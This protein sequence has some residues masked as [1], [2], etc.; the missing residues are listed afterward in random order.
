M[1]D[2]SC[3]CNTHSCALLTS[4]YLIILFLI[5]KCI[6]ICIRNNKTNNK[7]ESNQPKQPSIPIPTPN[8]NNTS[9]IPILPTNS[10]STAT[11]QD[12]S[13]LLRTMVNA[14]GE[15]TSQLQVPP[16]SPPLTEEQQR[17]RA[18]LARQKEKTET[19][20][21]NVVVFSAAETEEPLQTEEGA[22][23]EVVEEVEE[24]NI[25]E[26]EA[27]EPQAEAEQPAIED[28]QEEPIKQEKPKKKKPKKVSE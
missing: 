23:I 9:N 19:H 13:N 25:P 2:S 14:L 15:R 8:T 6:E 1:A 4:T 5:A 3:V 28:V 22:A 7:E 16:A 26:Q 27:E 12:A 10:V 18:R 17:R 11:V 21:R 20:T 24:C